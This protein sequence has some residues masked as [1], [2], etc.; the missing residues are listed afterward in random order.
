MEGP[1]PVR[2]LLVVTLRGRSYPVPRTRGGVWSFGETRL[3][4]TLYNEFARTLATR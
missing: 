3:A 1:S 2:F 4:Q